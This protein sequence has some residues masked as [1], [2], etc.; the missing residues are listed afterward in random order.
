MC[1]LFAGFTGQGAISQM[2]EYVRSNF[3]ANF[4]HL[5][6]EF[7]ENVTLV[8]SFFRSS[9]MNVSPRTNRS[10]IS[11][12][13]LNDSRSQKSAI[14]AK[15][16]P[17]KRPTVRNFNELTHYNVMMNQN[18]LENDLHLVKLPFW[19]KG[20]RAQRGWRGKMKATK[21]ELLR[22]TEGKAL[23]AKKPCLDRS[24]MTFEEDKRKKLFKAKTNM[25]A[26]A[27]ESDKKS[28]MS[29]RLSLVDS[30]GK[31]K[32]PFPPPFFINGKVGGLTPGLHN[33][34]ARATSARVQ[35]EGNRV[36]QISAKDSHRQIK[37]KK[38]I[39][40]GFQK[41]FNEKQKIEN[42]NKILK[43]KLCKSSSAESIY[44]ENEDVYC[45]KR[46]LRIPKK[47]L[48]LKKPL[49]PNFRSISRVSLDS[50]TFKYIQLGSDKLQGE[51]EKEEEGQDNEEK[52]KEPPKMTTTKSFLT[53]Q[54][55]L[56]KELML[57][58]NKSNK[59]NQFLTSK[60][61]EKPTPKI[62][63]RVSQDSTIFQKQ[64]TYNDKLNELS[65]NKNELILQYSLSNKQK[66]ANRLKSGDGAK[67]L[68]R[69]GTEGGLLPRTDRSRGKKKLS[70]DKLQIMKF[71]KK[72]HV[73]TMREIQKRQKQVKS[74]GYH[75]PKNKSKLTKLF[76][77]SAAQQLKSFKTESLIK[78]NFLK[79]M[80]PK[81]LDTQIFKEIYQK[82]FEEQE[83][84]EKNQIK[85][86]MSRNAANKKVN[87]L[88]KCCSAEDSA[89][90][91]VNPVFKE[92]A[93]RRSIGSRY[94]GEERN[95]S[96]QGPDPD[97]ILSKPTSNARRSYR[98]SSRNSSKQFRLSQ[99]ARVL[100]PN[101]GKSSYS[102]KPQKS[103]ISKTP[104]L[105]QIKTLK[106]QPIRFSKKASKSQ[107]ILKKKY[108]SK[109]NKL[110]NVNGEPW[111]KKNVLLRKGYT[112]RAKTSQL[113]GGQSRESTEQVSERGVVSKVDTGRSVPKF[114]EPLPVGDKK[115]FIRQDSGHRFMDEVDYV[116]SDNDNEISKLADKTKFWLLEMNNEN[117]SLG[118]KKKF[119][120]MNL[121]EKNQF[122][123][124]LNKKEFF[125][126][127][128]KFKK[129]SAKTIQKFGTEFQKLE[130]AQSK[131][132]QK[133]STSTSRASCST[134]TRQTSSPK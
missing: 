89:Y 58:T 118:Q 128:L 101:N 59:I 98:I 103:K 126:K 27:A 87:M 2:V 11:T 12:S 34:Q 28:Q 77:T 53:K 121:K 115:K 106:T 72:T 129:Q 131:P 92:V 33:G 125:S 45:Q 56:F 97:F 83:T 47:F 5:Y 31:E 85:K 24:I 13:A 74:R 132:D 111:K 67:V 70:E 48:P 42:N 57:K 96:V 102:L 52:T 9:Y 110:L 127:I 17:K 36:R 80:L 69:K 119:R 55:T 86:I 100:L 73:Q 82:Y 43:M 6:E 105:V 68:S 108:T 60:N 109:S 49:S 23:K 79:N 113:S 122:F 8:N 64:S 3:R 93:R 18:K 95:E 91:D 25:V 81:N 123:N 37:L 84:I 15:N 20:T 54:N 99:K 120:T 114:N 112:H 94:S 117:P 26:E 104:F 71:I 124:N 61:P 39:F 30:K 90:L 46:T 116:L 63:P 40:E 65:Q 50:N 133:R 41:F 66:V 22:V 29:E 38:N 134:S 19:E 16:T 62:S 32:K 7:L 35:M 88:K 1:Q 14:F 51:P 130:S 76:E 78:P 75:I 10:Q 107:Q 21:K 44:S 4:Y